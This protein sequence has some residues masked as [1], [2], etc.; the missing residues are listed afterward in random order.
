MS[1]ICFL[2][3][4]KERGLVVFDYFLDA[5]LKAKPVVLFAHAADNT[6]REMG[7]ARCRWEVGLC[8]EKDQFIKGCGKNK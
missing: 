3:Q 8:I 1:R 6:P 7:Q 2:L 4:S 5:L